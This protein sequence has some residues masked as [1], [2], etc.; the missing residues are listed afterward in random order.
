MEQN[1]QDNYYVDDTLV[2]LLKNMKHYQELQASMSK[3][4]ADGIFAMAMAR[5]QR[6]LFVA[7]TEDLREDFDALIRFDPI[8]HELILTNEQ[9]QQENSPGTCINESLLMVCALPPPALR[10]SQQ[11][12]QQA[13]RAIVQLQESKQSFL[14]SIEEIENYNERN[15]SL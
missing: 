15:S 3:S 8:N 1:S 5:K 9:D 4:I 7:S 2:S 14:S 10:K 11:Y 6:V 13:L 12:F